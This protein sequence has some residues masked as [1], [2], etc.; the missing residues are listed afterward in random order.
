MKVGKREDFI[1]LK[2]A[3]DKRLALHQEPCT[4]LFLTRTSLYELYRGKK[5]KK[6]N[7]SLQ[8]TY[9]PLKVP[10]GGAAKKFASKEK[11]LKVVRA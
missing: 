4:L 7:K 10:F 1:N 9:R 6:S 5:L 11:P 3:I 2:G 8:V